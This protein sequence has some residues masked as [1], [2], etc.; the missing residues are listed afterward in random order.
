MELSEEKIKKGLEDGTL[1][2]FRDILNERLK[3]PDYK[4]RFEKIYQEELEENRLLIRNRLAR[5]IKKA[6]KLAG[7]TQEELAR[8]M[9]TK[10]SYISALESGKQNIS[11]EYVVK[12]AT[13]LNRQVEIKIY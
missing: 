1:I 7:V 13:A 8:R 4:A 6:R 10:K 12:I 3:D 5:K 2:D 11:V 9:K